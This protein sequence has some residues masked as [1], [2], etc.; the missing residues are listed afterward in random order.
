[1]SSGPAVVVGPILEVLAPVAKRFFATAAGMAAAGLVAAALAGYS[2]VEGATALS[3]LAVAGLAALA[4][5]LVAALWIALGVMLATSRAVLRGADEAIWRH[6]LGRKLAQVAAE[7]AIALARAARS[8]DPAAGRVG[9][10]L[11]TIE[12]L[13]LD[14][15][16]GFL[17]RAVD[18]VLAE[19][20]PA[21]G[22][23]GLRAR[24]AGRLRAAALARVEKVLLA[25]LREEASAAGGARGKISLEKVLAEAGNHVDARAS[26]LVR[27]QARRTTLAVAL[28]L[29]AATA[30]PLAW[31]FA[32]AA[33]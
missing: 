23:A 4:A 33:R 14:E 18:A 30:A 7:R 3:P 31:A 5:A 22:L 12:D 10:A 6:A 26:A 8:G 21:A 17:R 19:P 20:V 28:V 2:V 29:I 15:A 25:S 32:I 11:A 16:E 1:M 9:A 27:A 24:L 13:P